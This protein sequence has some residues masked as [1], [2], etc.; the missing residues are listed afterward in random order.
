MATKTMEDRIRRL[1]FKP[2]EEPE[3]DNK[4]AD[5]ILYISHRC[6]DEPTFGAVML[7]KILH[8]ADFQ[9]FRRYGAPVTGSPYMKQPNGPVPKRFVPV[10]DRLIADKC[11]VVQE[12]PYFGKTQKRIVPLVVPD[13]ERFSGRDI[14][15]VDEAMRVLCR[16]SATEVSDLSHGVAWRAA[17]DGGLIPYEAALLS[18]EGITEADIYEAQRL[19]RE[20]GWGN[21]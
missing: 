18:N 6:Q 21:G 1:T 5:L 9:S 12:R 16:L 17:E 8:Y 15:M 10:R 13:L 7:N 20:R 4:L 11:I 19:S 14:A 2:V 3:S